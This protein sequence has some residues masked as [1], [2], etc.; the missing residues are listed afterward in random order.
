MLLGANIFYY[1]RSNFSFVQ[2]INDGPDLWVGN[3]HTMEV[4]FYHL[5]NLAV[6]S[7]S[8]FMDLKNYVFTKLKCITFGQCF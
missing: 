5:L 6:Y 8:S 1:L 7:I 3:I 2:K 4:L